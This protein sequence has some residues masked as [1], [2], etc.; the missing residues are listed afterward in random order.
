M[1]IANVLKLEQVDNGWIMTLSQWDVT[2][3]EGDPMRFVST[4]VEV[5]L[6][7]NEAQIVSRLRK[8]LILESA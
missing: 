3:P 1:T 8:Y 5:F 4:Q 7:G 6:T 2:K